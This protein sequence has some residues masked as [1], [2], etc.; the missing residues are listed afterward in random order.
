MVG[1][2]GLEGSLENLDSSLE[3]RVILAEASFSRV[4]INLT[5]LSQADTGWYECRL[6]IPN[7]TPSTRL[8]GTWFHLTVH[9][10]SNLCQR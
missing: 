10:E 7:R 5:S 4:D 9:G 1:M 8:N 6:V 3:G 2:V